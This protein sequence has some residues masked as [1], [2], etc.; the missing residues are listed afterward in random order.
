MKPLLAVLLGLLMGCV[1]VESQPFDSI[2]GFR[3]LQSGNP[4]VVVFR[5]RCEAIAP[6]EEKR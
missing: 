4:Q 1:A 5:V 6:G 3:Q 2:C